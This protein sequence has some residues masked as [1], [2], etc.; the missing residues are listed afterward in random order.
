MIIKLNNETF[1]PEQIDLVLDRAFLP[2]ANFLLAR[3]GEKTTLRDIKRNFPE[4]EALDSLVDFFVNFDLIKRHHGRYELSGDYVSEEYQKRSKDLIFNWLEGKEARFQEIFNDVSGEELTHQ[5]LTAL[6]KGYSDSKISFY[7]KTELSR[8]WLR[9][10]TRYT[11]IQ[12]KRGIY[13]SFG[14]YLPFYSHNISAYFNFIKLTS[15]ELPEE[16]L[17]LSYRLG[18]INPEYFIQYCERKLRRIEKGKIVSID[19]P[20]L[21]LESLAEM[22]YICKNETVYEWHSVRMAPNNDLS[23][24]NQKVVELIS[25]L[26]SEGMMMQIEFLSRVILFEWFMEKGLVKLPK[27]LHG[28][29]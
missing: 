15:S 1:N 11:E 6:F 8:K 17:N 9:Y 14:S 7:E 2:I 20:D 5:V 24:I 18:D 12:G 21:F 13:F 28:V 3:S 29:I 10:P 23:A 16:F 4:F 25:L 19:K 27:Q 26:E 22:G